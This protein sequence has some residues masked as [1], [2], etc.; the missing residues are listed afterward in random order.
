MSL[1]HAILGF[2]N[3]HPSTGYDLKR[4]FDSS[5]RHFWAADQGQIYRTLARLTDKGWA[6]MERVEQDDRPDRKVYQITETGRAELVRWLCA[7]PPYRDARSAVLVQVFFMGQLPDEEI[8]A[9]FEEHAELLRGILSRY[10][11]IPEQLEPFQQ[12]IDSPRERFFWLL[13]LE[14]GIASMHANL[15]WVESVI[16]RIK[17]GL[18][19]DR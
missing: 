4:I 3:Y 5:V 16:E 7:P 14:N 11:D 1:D 13:T 19:P 8:L 6:E 18:V 15:A 9:R 10:G 2:L 12:D 17:K